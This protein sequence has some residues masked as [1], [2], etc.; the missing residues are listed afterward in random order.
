[1]TSTSLSSL[2][3]VPWS[4]LIGAIGLIYVLDKIIKYEF[5]SPLRKL[6]GP[7]SSILSIIHITLV[8]LFTK[9]PYIVVAMHKRYGSLVRTGPTTVWVSDIHMVRRLLS[10]H[11]FGKSEIFDAFKLAG[12][13]LFS[14]RNVEYHKVQKRLMLPAYSPNALEQL[15]PMIYSSG[16]A[17]LIDRIDKYVD[18]GQSMD[19]LH[20]LSCMTFD[21]IG[22]VAFGKSFNLLSET[23]DSVPIVKWMNAAT[24]VGTKKLLLGRF[25]HQAFAPSDSRL[26]D[27]LL[28]F[29]NET[30]EKRRNSGQSD[31]KDTLQQLIDSVDEETGATMS[32]EDIIAQTLILMIAGTDTTALSL[33]WI[34]YLLVEHPACLQKLRDE[35][36]TAYP[37]L[38]VK[39]TN[40]ALQSL[41][42]LDA[43]L[44]EALRIRAIVPYGLSR[45]I[46]KE[47]V[48]LGDDFLPGGTTISISLNALY[49]NEDVYPDPTVFKPERWFTTPEKLAEMKQYFLP[50]SMGPRS[51]IGRNLA[52]MEI[53]LTVAELVRR[54]DFTAMPDNDMTPVNWFILR[55][56]ASKYMVKPQRI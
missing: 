51:C 49:F 17:C 1:M 24:A 46:P 42:Y 19:I 48:T 10:T 37:D 26:V 44:H 8:R 55:P 11:K 27:K 41:P 2:S 5:T 32:D 47:G 36:L 34:V 43:L 23:K 6:P 54:F 22:E 29:A 9:N 52:W 21:V 7:R 16:I 53:R 18:D 50:F 25:F 28:K 33:T 31:R 35:I 39:P 3:T 40:E 38:S 12:D 15:E 45:L 56:R 30:V 4:K 20:L 13:N 14:T